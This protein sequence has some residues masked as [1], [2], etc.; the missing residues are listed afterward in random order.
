MDAPAG[1]RRIDRLQTG[2]LV[3]AAT[4]DVTPIHCVMKGITFFDTARE[5]QR[6]VL[7]RAGNLGPH[8]PARDL[9]VSA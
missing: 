1:A 3:R 5:D 9:I 4:G 6:P 7:I 2:D 8:R